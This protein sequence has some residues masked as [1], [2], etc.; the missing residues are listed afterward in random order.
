MAILTLI[1]SHKSYNAWAVVEI[2]FDFSK[3]SNTR[4]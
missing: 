2:D 1:V 3:G 4:L